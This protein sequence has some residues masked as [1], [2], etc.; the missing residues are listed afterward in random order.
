MR[1]LAGLLRLA[2]PFLMWPGIRPDVQGVTAVGQQ[3]V[4]VE[5]V[6]GRFVVANHKPDEASQR[7][8]PTDTRAVLMDGP[9]HCS[10][11]GRL[12]GTDGS[13]A[14]TRRPR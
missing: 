10:L 11:G 7:T 13:G 4:H 2:D 5:E 3:Y 9:F 14:G 6:V 1:F 12:C 8:S